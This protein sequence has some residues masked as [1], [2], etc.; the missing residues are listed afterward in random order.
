MTRQSSFE[1]SYKDMKDI[2]KELETQVQIHYRIFVSKKVP[3]IPNYGTWDLLMNR[4]RLETLML[5]D[6]MK[7]DDVLLRSNVKS[8]FEKK[9]WSFK[10]NMML[11]IVFL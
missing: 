4:N 3:Y 6:M 9:I 10:Y 2:Y 8:H 7:N 11:Q 1:F 5:E